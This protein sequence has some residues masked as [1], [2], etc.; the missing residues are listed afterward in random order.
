MMVVVTTTIEIIA[1]QFYYCSSSYPLP[2]GSQTWQW[3]IPIQF[4][5]FPVKISISFGDFPANHV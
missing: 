1:I 5:D 3:K 2:S 4:D